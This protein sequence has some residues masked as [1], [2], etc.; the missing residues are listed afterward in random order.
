MLQN[1]VHVVTLLALNKQLHY[2][3]FLDFFGSCIAKAYFLKNFVVYSVLK[4]E[5][6]EQDLVTFGL[7]I[8][9]PEPIR[10]SI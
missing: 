1:P 7:L 9:N 3:S 2:F 6:H 8:L 4:E 10:L 5:P